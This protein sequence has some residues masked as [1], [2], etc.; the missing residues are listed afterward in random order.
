[1]KERVTGKSR[2]LTET[3]AKQEEFNIEQD[4]RKIRG[5]PVCNHITNILADFFA[6]LQYEL[7][8]DESTRHNYAE[9]LG[10]CPFHAWQLES[11]SSPLGIA[12]SYPTVLEHVASILVTRAETSSRSPEKALKVVRD[13][14][15]CSA[16][17]LLE[18]IENNYIKHLGLFLTDIDGRQAYACSHGTCLKHLEQLINAVSAP[19]TVRFLLLDE[20]ERLKRISADL[21]N[22]VYKRDALRRDLLTNNEKDAYRRALIKTA[23]GRNVYAQGDRGGSL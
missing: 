3:E 19:V 11:F 21:R 16:C 17:H 23:S 10:L 7:S 5:C 6:H 4:L 18:K 8:N 14:A 15:T 13:S 1:M 20:A 22:Y 9:E 2:I 12:R